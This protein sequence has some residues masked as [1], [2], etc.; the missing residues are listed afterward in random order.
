MVDRMQ[1]VLRYREAVGACLTDKLKASFE[2]VH[3]IK[4]LEN[5]IDP[6]T[7]GGLHL[8]QKGGRMIGYEAFLASR[9]REREEEEH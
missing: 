2:H 1:R 9:Q 4:P 7:L 3:I 6:V 5:T 8:I